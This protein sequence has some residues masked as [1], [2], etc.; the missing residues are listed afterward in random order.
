MTKKL[1]ARRKK[2]SVLVF[3]M[4]T[5]AGVASAFNEWL[6]RY[7]ET[8]DQFLRE[9]QAVNEFQQSEANGAEPDYG[10]TCADYLLKLVKERAGIPA[11]AKAKR[12][13][14]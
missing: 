14:R 7:I 9:F 13:R 4:A 8:P 10:K 3:K 2:T 11:R 1:P 12:R 6:R 5:H